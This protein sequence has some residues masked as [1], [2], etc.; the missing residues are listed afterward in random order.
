MTLEDPVVAVAE[1]AGLNLPALDQAS[2]TTEQQLARFRDDLDES[3]SETPGIGVVL[4]GSFARG[5]VVPD[6]DCDFLVIV[7]DVT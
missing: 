6:S 4:T 5:E 1:S 3:L 2:V 7:T